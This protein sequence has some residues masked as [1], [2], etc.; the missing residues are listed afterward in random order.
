MKFRS[1]TCFFALVSLLLCARLEAAVLI[2][3]YDFG[4]AADLGLDSSGNGNEAAAWG[5]TQVS[6][7]F[8]GTYRG[9]LCQQLFPASNAA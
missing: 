2:A 7:P 5:V 4:S 3:Q 8:A 6:G 9:L 1:G